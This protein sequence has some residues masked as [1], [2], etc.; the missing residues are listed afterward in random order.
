MVFLFKKY[1][2]SS[3][4]PADMCTES[5]SGP[6]ISWSNKWMNGFRF[7]PTSYTEHYQIVTLNDF[8]IN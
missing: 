2:N 8:I 6:I 7:Y 3:V 5:C 1:D 4:L